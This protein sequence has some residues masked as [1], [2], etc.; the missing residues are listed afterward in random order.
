MVAPVIAAE[1]LPISNTITSLPFRVVEAVS[2]RTF[3]CCACPVIAVSR[4]VAPVKFT[5][6]QSGPIAVMEAPQNNQ[7]LRQDNA[8]ERLKKER[9]VKIKQP[10]LVDVVTYINV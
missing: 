8:Q 9:G 5:I 2:R 7:Q 1:V 3:N 6:E 4:T 10:I